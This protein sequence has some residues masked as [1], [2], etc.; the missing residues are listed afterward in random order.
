MPAGLPPLSADEL[1]AV[2]AWIESGAPKEGPVPAPSGM[3]ESDHYV[4]SVLCGETDSADESDDDGPLVAPEPNQ[5]IQFRMAP[6]PLAAGQEWEGCFATY[7]DVSEQVPDEY[8]SPDGKSFYVDSTTTRLARGSHHM[9]A[10]L[11]N[12]TVEQLS[13]EAFGAWTCRGGD[14]SGDAC[15]PSNLTGCGDGSCV[16]TPT[17]TAGCLGYGPFGTENNAAGFGLVQALNA[18]ESVPRIAG[19][20]REVPLKAVVFW[21]FHGFNLT[22]EDLEADGRINM[23]FASERR[24][25]ERR[26]TVSGA[27]DGPNAVPPFKRHR[28]CSAWTVPQGTEVLRLT[29]HTHQRASNFRVFDPG[30]K[31]IYKS[32]RYREPAYVTFDPIIRFDAA[33][34]EDRVVKFCADFNNGINEDGMPDMTL[35][36]QASK[37]PD[38]EIPIFVP[39]PIACSTG[40]WGEPCIALLGDEQCDS[41]LGSGDGRCDATNIHY[42]LTTAGEMFYL[43][44]DVVVPAGEGAQEDLSTSYVFAE[45]LPNEELQ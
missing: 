20:Y 33:L 3:P 44:V 41:S 7:Y 6:Q 1:S 45:G 18:N 28:L 42:G 12:V 23:T 4:A 35:L 27:L 17:I 32:E 14:K 22:D 43:A 31:E 10:T 21:D 11:P 15:E 38:Y 16:S 26:I 5:G 13:D 25:V 30:G 29:S 2:S 9:S 24:M 8:K 40:R 37:T 34:D 39:D 36:S 19:V